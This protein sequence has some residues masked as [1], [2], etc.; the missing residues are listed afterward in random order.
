M[1]I[2]LKS[3]GKSD[4]E[5]KRGGARKYNSL[6]LCKLI[7]AI[8]IV[9]I[10]TQPLEKCEIDLVNNIYESFVRMAVPFFFITSGF[11]LGNKME[12]PSTGEENKHIIKK[13]LFKII[14]MYLIWTAI[15]FPLAVYH[16][17]SADKKPILA[18]LLYIRKF[19]FVGEQYNSWHLW[20]LL[21]TI[22]ALLFILILMKRKLSIKSILRVGGVLFIISILITY[23]TEYEGALPAPVHVIQKLFQWSIG[24]GRIL[25]GAFYIPLGIYFSKKKLPGWAAWIMMI[26][27]YFANVIVYSSSMSTFWV[28]VSAIGFFEIVKEINLPDSDI[29]QT[30][31]KMSTVIYFIHMYVWSFY[32]KFVYGEKTYG[33]DSFAVTTCICVVIA[34]IYVKVMNSRK[35]LQD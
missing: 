35:H 20:Y 1:D 32:Y 7:M 21:S 6:D 17:I 24:E 28:A 13:Y 9:A 5:V 23:L 15:Y 14:K 12:I 26:G 27:G 8:C 3:I 4:L 22:Y 18:V 10:H 33:L 11:L 29:Y 34:F 25:T 30:V 16:F 2:S 31:R 19:I